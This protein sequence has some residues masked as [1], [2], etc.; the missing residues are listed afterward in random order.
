[1]AHFFP[2]KKIHKVTWEFPDQTKQNQIDHITIHKKWR[3]SLLDVR[4]FRGADVASDHQLLVRSVQLKTAA[5]TVRDTADRPKFNTD[6]LKSKTVHKSMEKEIEKI[7]QRTQNANECTEKKWHNIQTALLEASE[8]ILGRSKTRGKEWISDDTWGRIA[9]R[10]E[11]K[12]KLLIAVNEIEKTNLIRQYREAN[13]LVKKPA[14]KNKRTWV[15][16]LAQAAQN[17]ADLKNS[18]ELYRITRQLAKK[19]FTNAASLVRRKD[20]N[21]LTAVEEQVQR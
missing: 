3:R 19:S 11:F 14:R 15:E 21:Q 9:K 16:N 12:G 13:K 18:R 8:E 6:K 17:A 2:I 5:L 7:I 10:K 4:A 1:M 20:G